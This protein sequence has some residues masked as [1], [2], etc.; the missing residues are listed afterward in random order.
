MSIAAGLSKQAPNDQLL[1]SAQI[2]TS[3]SGPERRRAHQPFLFP[4]N[5][6]P[7]PPTMN[8]TKGF[9][10]PMGPRLPAPKPGGP[11][12]PP[13]TLS[14]HH[15]PLPSP[16]PTPPPQPTAKA[17]PKLGRLD[18]SKDEKF[19]VYAGGP[20]EG[21]N[22]YLSPGSGDDG[23]TI[24]PPGTT[25]SNGGATILARDATHQQPID[26]ITQ[27]IKTISIGKSMADSDSQI[28]TISSDWSDDDFEEIASLG[29]GAG[30]A[31]HKVKHKKTGRLI[32][33]K[34]ITTREAP[35][36]QLLRELNIMSSTTH[37]NIV[38]FYGVYMSPSSSEV[39]ILMELCEGG[40][41]ESVAK[42]IRERG[43]IVGEKIA[44]RIAEGVSLDLSSC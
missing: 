7:H 10:R 39:K 21:A 16:T 35:M 11:R 23:K 42:K 2:V 12:G 4:A 15:A 38:A 41:L 32:A 6:L 13:L 8:T 17:K 26:Q 9:Q 31:V 18:I 28:S 3:F 37:P 34:T 1:V 20:N 29:E 40:S 33:R 30:G 24:V 36:K 19:D 25:H 22:T 5:L 44:G 43:A 27:R 14:T